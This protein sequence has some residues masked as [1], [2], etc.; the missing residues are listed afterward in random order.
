MTSTDPTNDVSSRDATAAARWPAPAPFLPPLRAHW[1]RRPRL[2]RRLPSGDARVLVTAPAGWGKTT[3]LTQ[4]A[5]LERGTRHVAWLALDATADD[6]GE[7][8]ARLLAAVG[9]ATGPSLL[10]LDDVDAVTSQ[11]SQAMLTALVASPSPRLTIV[12]ASRTEPDWLP[13]GVTEPERLDADDLAFT[14]LEATVLLQ[15]TVGLDLGVDRIA[16][17]R[18]HTG[19]WPGALCVAASAATVPGPVSGFDEDLIGDALTEYV[20]DAY[21]PEIDAELRTFLHRTSILDRLDTAACAAVTGSTQAEALLA[22][23][24]A[25]QHVVPLP[26]SGSTARLR[27]LVRDVLRRRLA[28]VDGEVA[29]RQLHRRAAAWF[30]GHGYLA[31]ALHHA[32]EGADQQR[33][34]RLGPSYWFDLLRAGRTADL[35]AWRWAWEWGTTQADPR[36]ALSIAWLAAASGDTDALAAWSRLA[37]EGIVREAVDGFA[38]GISSFAV[39]QA[40]ASYQPIADLLPVVREAVAREA[41]G[42][43]PGEASARLALAWLSYLRG[44][45][46]D[47]YFT[48]AATA[49]AGQPLVLA[50]TLTTSTLAV[51]ERDPV[52][53]G[54]LAGEA[55]RRLR[56]LGFAD[57][58]ITWPALLVAGCH[59]DGA[60]PEGAARLRDRAWQ[61]ARRFDPVS[62]WPGIVAATILAAFAL[63]RGD[64]ERAATVLAEAQ[65]LRRRYGH[66]D[67][68]LFA[69]MD[70]LQ[71]RLAE[72][73]DE[74]GHPLSERELQVL[75]R[76]QGRL[77]Q[78]EIAKQL[79]VSP[80]TLKSHV[81][82]VYRK[83]G[84]RSRSEAVAS[85][86]RRG[87][88]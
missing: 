20:E 29:V 4:W 50:A 31:E 75:R 24:R 12:L 64:R 9:W 61:Q 53:A 5:H 58:P 38:S 74:F 39:L 72:L 26:S 82:M 59:D 19:G 30:E 16:D 47:G 55:L 78:T 81:R 10:L 51:L 2:L 25:Q 56:R 33:L 71:Q 8:G 66:D 37:A 15:R 76:L 28:D 79:G 22:R 23:A 43:T 63:D 34:G 6:P 40:L 45:A 14:D 80:N 60:D 13:P 68:R 49:A 87:L 11:P 77:D 27:P 18:E 1:L 62:P 21:L 32:I 44:D 86:R 57:H 7:L 83:L 42:A 73:T 41:G 48:E 36:R 85:A 70:A 35:P 65:V 54:E 46:T 52:Q 67:G 17:L 3:L 69:R 84:A 88:V